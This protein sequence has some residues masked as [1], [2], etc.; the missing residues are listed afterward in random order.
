MSGLFDDSFG[1]EDLWFEERIRER[2]RLSQIQVSEQSSDIGIRDDLIQEAR[3]KIWQILQERPDAVTGLL[4]VA[5]K[6]RIRELVQRG[7]KWT[8]MKGRQ[9]LERDPLRREW[10]TTDDEEWPLLIEAADVLSGVE[11][12]YHHGEILDAIRALP[13]NHQE[14]VMLRFW[15]GFTN[16]E[17]AA[18]QEVN[19]G[20]M[21]RMWKD[22]I[23]PRLGEAL[24]HLVDA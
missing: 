2:D 16:V 3:I 18:V 24:H 1:D 14:Y 12:A 22:S 5:T 23:R 17:I 10:T 21:A 13:L 20:N 8:G 4:S 7:Q 9:G 6:Y 19:A 11:M 15:G